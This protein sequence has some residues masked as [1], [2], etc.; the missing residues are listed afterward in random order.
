MTECGCAPPKTLNLIVAVHG[1][2]TGRGDPTWPERL[3]RWAASHWPGVAVLTDQYDSG[4]FPVWNCFLRNPRAAK[5]LSRVVENWVDQGESDGQKVRVHLVAHSNGCDIVRRL[6]IRLMSRGYRVESVLL[7][8]GAVQNSAAKMGLSPFLSV[9]RLGRLVVYSADGDRVLA[10]SPDWSRPWTVA[11][12]CARWP[13]GNAGR[14]GISDANLVLDGMG[15]SIPDGAPISVNRRFPGWEH[16]DFFPA[17]F[18]G[19]MN[20]VFAMIGRD[21]NLQIPIP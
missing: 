18:P 12:S 16:G 15:G 20:A 17:L 13:Y 6:A 4:P 21:S 9:G 19:R 11:L 7:F 3:E 1:I 2:L 14:V 5:A 8:S 10:P